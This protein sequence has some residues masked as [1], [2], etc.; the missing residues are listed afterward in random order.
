M[1]ISNFAVVVTLTIGL[2][3]AGSAMAEEHKDQAPYGHKE[4]MKRSHGVIGISL[5]IGA[6]HI[7]EPAVLYVGMVHPQ[8][9]AYKAG[10]RHGDEVTSVDGISLKGKSHE[11]V[12]DMIRG[13]A[14]NHR[15]DGSQG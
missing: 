9:P 13:E 14:G 4:D 2:L 6:E 8:G 11:Q 10:L 3:V 1:R 7:G 12:A 15:E 5:H